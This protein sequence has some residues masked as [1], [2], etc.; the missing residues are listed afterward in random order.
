[1]LH[2]LNKIKEIFHMSKFNLK[3]HQIK[4]TTEKYRKLQ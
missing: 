4:D 2:T 1:M 3:N